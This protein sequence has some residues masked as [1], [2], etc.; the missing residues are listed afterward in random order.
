MQSLVTISPFQCRMWA[1]HD[2]LDTQIT[3]ASCRAEIE[4]FSKHGQLVPVLGRALR[5]DLNYKVELIYGA[6][7]L[8]VARHINKPL[9][10]E[11]KDVSDREGIIAMD[12]ENRQRTDI[13]PYERG[14]SYL[15]WV[16]AGHFHSQDEV[17]RALKL[18]ASQVS[19][20]LK[21]ARL[22]S[23]V[24]GA[25]ANP[26]EICEA[27]GLDLAE[28]LE[29]PQRR[30][31][32]LQKARTIAAAEARPVARE[33]YRQ[34]LTAAVP[35]RKPKVRRR[36]EIIKGSNGERLFRVRYQSNSVAL[37]LAA[38]KVSA[39]SLKRICEA[40]SGVLQTANAQSVVCT[41][42]HRTESTVGNGAS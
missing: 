5:G 35:G 19:R 3:E 22:P 39:S 1:F 11:L 40:I 10:V 8:F 2:R 18:S 23:V 16:Q 21:L 30:P 9:L 36:D 38:D 42:H 7:R 12:I 32:M 41:R 17:A 24:V 6:R 28:A 15:R 26:A 27:W 29:D 13:S 14:L 20:L 34:L 25:F 37:L 33:I 4:S 31:Q